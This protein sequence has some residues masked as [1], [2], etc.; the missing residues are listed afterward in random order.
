MKSEILPAVV[1]MGIAALC[2]ALLELVYQL[3]GAMPVYVLTAVIPTP[4]GPLPGLYAPLGIVGF[5]A[6]L[7]WLSRRD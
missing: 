6:L 3:F 2:V 4:Y 1:T 5:G 7:Y